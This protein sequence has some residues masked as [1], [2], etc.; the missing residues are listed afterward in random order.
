[1][2]RDTLTSGTVLLTIVPA[3]TFVVARKLLGDD[4]HAKYEFR[5][6]RVDNEH[7]VPTLFIQCLTKGRW[8]YMGVVHP[9]KGT[10]RLT[11]KSAFP[12][13]ATRVRVADRVL[14]AL[15]AGRADQI[16]VAGWAVTCE[17]LTE[18][19]ERF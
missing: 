14:Q 2:T 18:I 1:M 19:S 9:L 15:F 8:V 11:T 16:E 4:F 3:E 17:V 12:S 6:E 10:I 5:I 7:G 13:H